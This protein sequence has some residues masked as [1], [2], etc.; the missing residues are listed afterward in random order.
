MEEG[1]GMEGAERRRILLIVLRVK[2]R[3]SWEEGRNEEGGRFST[4]PIRSKRLEDSGGGEA[5]DL[6]VIGDRGV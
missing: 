5:A 1:S 6:E 3:M 2:L 4:E